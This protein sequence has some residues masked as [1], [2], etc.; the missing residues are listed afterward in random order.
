MPAGLVWV[1]LN[2]PSEAERQFVSQQL[3]I[4]LPTPS[5]MEEIE[6]SSRLYTEHGVMYL[7]TMVMSGSETPM[8]IET[9]LTIVQAP[10]CLVTMRFAETRS[11]ETFAYRIKRDPNLMTTPD[12]ALISL[13]DA[14]IDRMADILELIGRHVDD[15]S[16]QVFMRHEAEKGK[17]KRKARARGLHDI[18]SDI[19]R[20]G[21]MVHRVRDCL[22]NL[23]RLVAFI[24]PIV[25]PRLHGE[26]L[27]Y[28]RT[29][30]RDL[31][32]L[33][34]HSQFLAHEASFLLEATLGQINIEQNEIIKIFTVA[35]VA[36]LPP[37]MLAS[38]WGMNFVHMPELQTPWGY[39]L[40]LAIIFI[41][42]IIP[43]ALFRRKGWI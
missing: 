13:L 21:D 5:E 23:L 9:E 10:Q 16:R 14:I 22:S 35:S 37:T 19:G 31:R 17:V 32:S 4:D 33:S 29:L 36:F 7:T 6:A 34:D 40:A 26:Q 27:T 18:L 28:F 11:L 25:T 12:E 2:S 1:D 42:G 38:I 43:I 30:D 39:W 41:S 8:P 24:S 15:V 3:K 20:S